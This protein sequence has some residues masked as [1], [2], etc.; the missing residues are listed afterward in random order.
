MDAYKRAVAMMD[1]KDKGLIACG[2]ASNLDL[3][4]GWDEELVQSWV[5]RFATVPRHYGQAFTMEEVANLFLYHLP[6][7]GTECF[8]S[9]EIGRHI[10][11]EANVSNRAVGGTGTH[12]AKVLSLLGF[13]ALLHMT[14]I[15]SPLLE[16]LRYPS[17][18]MASA[19]GP[20]SGM[21]YNPGIE[22]QAP[23]YIFQFPKGACLTF[24]GKEYRAPVAN[25][26]MLSR[27]D[28]N[29]HL[30]LQ[31]E[32]FHAL[33]DRE[34]VP[35]LL[36][37][38]LSNLVNK[39][40]LVGHPRLLAKYISEMKKPPL[41]YYECGP[42]RVPDGLTYM[43][44]SFHTSI[45]I[46]GCSDEEI[47]ALTGET[48]TS[49]EGLY[50]ALCRTMEVLKPQKG[51]V[52]HTREGA[53]YYGNP[54]D[55]DIEAG[56]AMGGLTASTKARLGVY[57]TRGQVLAIQDEPN[58]PLGE[59]MRAT[60]APKGIIFVPSKPVEHP[61]ASIGLGDTFTAGVL[62]CF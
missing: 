24:Q 36:L 46:L 30:P 62:T 8:V 47:F 42:F 58:S 43:M 11:T 13:P 2:L 9:P 17:L 20:V 29:T 23:H 31:P 50:R 1:R 26:I 21:E 37:S 22:M 15:C 35:V 54:L 44:E 57:G 59:E 27:N 19:E 39:E 6:R 40:D 14:V 7:G 51:L 32:F 49:A 41:V 16:H 52:L 55:C 33:R 28:V 5:D 56:L 25:K 34:D 12:A 60:L 3:L 48:D 18:S 53:L 38:A 61:T 45:D 4:I 10:E